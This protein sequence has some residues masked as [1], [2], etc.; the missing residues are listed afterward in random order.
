M[1]T[2]VLKDFPRFLS[3]KEYCTPYKVFRKFFGYQNAEKWQNDLDSIADAALSEHS[4]DLG[5][6]M[7]AI[8]WHLTKLIESCPSD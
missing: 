5:F 4:H 6:E 2:D 1:V 8:Y 3:A 7:I